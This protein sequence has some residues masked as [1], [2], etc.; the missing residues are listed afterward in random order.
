MYLC[1]GYI[2]KSLP[3]NIVM[4]LGQFQISSIIHILSV[5]LC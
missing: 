3:D 4:Q 2:E 1:Q 5:F